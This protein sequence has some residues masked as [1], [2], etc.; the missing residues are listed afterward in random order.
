MITPDD[1]QYFAPG[2]AN[3]LL[4][5]SEF[6]PVLFTL[7]TTLGKFANWGLNPGAVK[8]SDFDFQFVLLVADAPHPK[9]SIP[10]QVH[11]IFKHNGTAKASMFDVALI[12]RTGG[13][14][15]AGALLELA[16]QGE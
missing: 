4:A 1:I 3:K 9:V 15:T 6:L 12:E 7:D 2:H 5:A 13:Y 16:R 11:V 10:P 14:A 8:V